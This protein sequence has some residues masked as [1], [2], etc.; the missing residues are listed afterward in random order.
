M[1]V[2]WVSLANA[3]TSASLAGG[4]DPPLCRIFS[5]AKQ[6]IVINRILIWAYCPSKGELCKSAQSRTSTSRILLSSLS[7][8][9]GILSDQKYSF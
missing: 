7:G 1:R 6:E 4:D 9:M 5:S 2:D 8:H 3:R